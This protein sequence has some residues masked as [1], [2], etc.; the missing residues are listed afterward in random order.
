MVR[1]DVVPPRLDAAGD[2]GDHPH[3]RLGRGLARDAVVA[4]PDWYIAMLLRRQLV[5][6]EQPVDALAGV[7]VLLEAGVVVAPL[8]IEHH[9][10]GARCRSPSGRGTSAPAR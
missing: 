1:A 7:A 4:R 5:P 3:P 9:D 10:V 2:A 6:A 8:V